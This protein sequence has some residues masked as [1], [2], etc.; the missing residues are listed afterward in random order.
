MM[1]SNMDAPTTGVMAVPPKN[2]NTNSFEMG[3]QR[4]L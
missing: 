3:K 2:T 4:V 1:G